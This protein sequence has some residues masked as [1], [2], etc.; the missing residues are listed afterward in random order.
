MRL[1]NC[2]FAKAM[3][4]RSPLDRPGEPG[5]LD[6]TMSR[7]RQKVFPEAGQ[8][9]A[10]AWCQRG[11]QKGGL[12][13]TSRERRGGTL[14]LKVAELKNSVRHGGFLLMAILGFK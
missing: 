3:I 7:I 10:P 2:E 14:G 4:V 12:A 9:V 11:S 1:V 13:A 6:R 8:S 5:R